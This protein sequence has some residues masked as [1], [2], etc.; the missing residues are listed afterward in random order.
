M[1]RKIRSEKSE[2]ISERLLGNRGERMLKGYS[3]EERKVMGL[4]AE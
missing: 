4:V 1:E 2:N 3:T